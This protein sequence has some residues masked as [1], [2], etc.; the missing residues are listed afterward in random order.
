MSLS[1][2]AWFWSWNTQAAFIFVLQS[3]PAGASTVLCKLHHILN[4]ISRGSWACLVCLCVSVH[5]PLLLSPSL[6]TASPIAFLHLASVAHTWW[7]DMC[8]SYKL[9]EVG[10]GVYVGRRNHSCTLFPNSTCQLFSKTLHCQRHFIVTGYL[11]GDFW[12]DFSTEHCKMTYWFSVFIGI[13]A[14]PN[15]LPVSF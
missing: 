7:V 15:N 4:L 9:C 5:L 10:K 11:T 8:K 6:V 13:S 14:F 1:L 12:I 3:Q 2:G